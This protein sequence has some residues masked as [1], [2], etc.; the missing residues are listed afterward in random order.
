[1]KNI[2]HQ[3]AGV[4]P[5]IHI[6]EPTTAADTAAGVSTTGE[7]K[8][9]VEQVW[10]PTLSRTFTPV[11]AYFL[12]NAHRLGQPG[13]KGLNP[14]EMMVI[15]QILSF[16]WGSSAPFP[17]LGTI[18]ERLGLSVRTVRDTVKRLEDLGY[19]RREYNPNG[20]RSRYHFGGLFKRLEALMA[21]DIAAKDAKDVLE[22]A[23]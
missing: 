22:A 21:A 5:A 12:A 7:S 11:S 8:Y 2:Q 15:I 4:A 19:I 23:A 9:G 16:K 17:A 20:G 1:M 3:A 18:G 13:S 10:G 6:V 14:T